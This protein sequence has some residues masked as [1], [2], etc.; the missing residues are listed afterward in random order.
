MLSCMVPF[1]R[2][3]FYLKSTS[4]VSYIQESRQLSTRRST[5]ITD[6]R[7]DDDQK[8]RFIPTKISI[9]TIMW[10]F[11]FFFCVS[12]VVLERKIKIIM[13]D[14]RRLRSLVVLYGRSKC[15]KPKCC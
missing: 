7:I 5:V 6:E 15:R 1:I 14:I 3:M 8:I 12:T 10:N 2:F 9:C 4:A 11:F 13:L